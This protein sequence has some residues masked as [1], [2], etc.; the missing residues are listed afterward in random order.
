MEGNGMA[1]Y[2]GCPRKGRGERGEQGSR[3]H[4]LCVPVGPVGEGLSLGQKKELAART[5]INNQA[6]L[7]VRTSGE[8]REGSHSWLT[9]IG[10]RRLGDSEGNG[11]LH[12]RTGTSYV[13][14]VSLPFFLP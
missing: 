14:F 10:K 2:L 1:L 6:G 13:L 12:F 5:E 8:K 3:T 4:C 7:C 9:L 11:H